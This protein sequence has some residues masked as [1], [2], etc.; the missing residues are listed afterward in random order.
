MCRKAHGAPFATYTSC[1]ADA[2]TLE[3]GQEK[4]V[5]YTSAPGMTRE[6]CNVCGAVVPRARPGEER[7]DLALGSLDAPVGAEPVAHIFAADAPAWFIFADSLP[8]HDAW[9]QDGQAVFDTPAREAGTKENCRG[10]C[11]CGAVVYE[12]ALPFRVVHNCHCSRCRRARAAAHTTNGFV[13]I[14]ALRWI[15]G[16]ENVCNYRYE[17]GN[18]MGQSFC[19]TCGGKVARERPEVGIVGVPLAGLDGD[20]GKGAD[21]HIYMGS[22]ARWYDPQDDLPKFGEMPD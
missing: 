6:F 14:E 1:D 8:R 12:I 18:G 21:D 10:S 19:T 3:S 16:A 20:P 15:R 11:L 5:S 22:R 13:P 4:I 2:F 9:R 7:V 17:R